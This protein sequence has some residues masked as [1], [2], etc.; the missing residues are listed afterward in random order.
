MVMLRNLESLLSSLNDER[1]RLYLES[2][3]SGCDHNL[4]KVKRLILYRHYDDALTR[5]LLSIIKGARK[6]NVV[7]DL[8]AIDDGPDAID[9]TGSLMI[10]QMKLNCI[11]M[12]KDVRLHRL[13]SIDAR[14]VIPMIPDDM[15]PK[16]N[17]Y[18]RN[19]KF[20]LSKSEMRKYILSSLD[21]IGESISQ[22]TVY[23]SVIP[24]IPLMKD[25]IY[26]WCVASPGSIRQY[27]V[28]HMEGVSLW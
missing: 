22:K 20:Q 7:L 10:E 6:S 12:A 1:S 23:G 27:I 14:L 4:S 24:L 5:D 28:D 16:F 13:K 19:I 11:V 17:V 8:M 25:G 18:F 15:I 26:Y 2:A 21:I 3:Y 9:H